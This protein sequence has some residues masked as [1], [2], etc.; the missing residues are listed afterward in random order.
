MDETE[1][2][3]ES[4]VDASEWAPETEEEP[5]STKRRKPIMEDHIAHYIQLDKL[6]AEEIDRKKRN[7][8]AGIRPLQKIYKLI[9]VMKKEMPVVAKSK[10]AKQ[11]FS[12]RKNV[13][14]G[15]SRQHYI[16]AELASFLQ[17]D[18]DVDTMSRVDFA[19]ALSAYIHIKEDE[20]RED[21]LKWSYLNNGR[22][23]QN[24]DNKRTFIPDKAISKLLRLDQYK[25]NVI[26]GKIKI[27]CKNRETGE[28]DMV[29]PDYTNLDF[30]QVQSLIGVHLLDPVTTEEYPGWSWDYEVGDW[31]EDE[32]TP[33]DVPEGEEE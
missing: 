23:L 19:R 28:I 10:L 29:K 4:E 26:S 12:T 31:V 21:I 30:S 5:T 32:T 22:N 14:S 27:K 8:E 16:S 13:K 25:K 7:K 15:F 20:T 2:D 9:L 17:L 18:V 3:I 24:P 1:W 6:L 11:A 33:E